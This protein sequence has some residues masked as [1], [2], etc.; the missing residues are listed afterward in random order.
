M[1]DYLPTILILLGLGIMA[2]ILTKSNK[3]GHEERSAAAQENNWEYTSKD[4]SVVLGKSLDERNIFYEVEGVT[5]KGDSWKLTA[6]YRTTVDSS[7][8]LYEST[9]WQS[10]HSFNNAILIIPID[11][12]PIP[13]IIVNEIFKQFELPP[14]INRL[15]PGELPGNM[16]GKYE[17]FLE[18]KK[19]I[20][21]LSTNASLLMHWRN[22][23]KKSGQ[24]ITLSA[25]AQGI[26]MRVDWT[27][28]KSRDMVAF[29]NIGLAFVEN[30]V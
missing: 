25:G 14:T 3:S 20:E 17:V 19:D 8:Q 7:K 2:V 10:D 18:D 5:K 4:S 15:T 16:S 6:R 27:L 24:G 22:E 12:V 11:G 23:Y 28:E 29:I 9:W 13:D 26:K 21:L 1:L 30:Q